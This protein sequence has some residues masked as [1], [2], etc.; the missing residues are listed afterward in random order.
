MSKIQIDI[1]L[2][3]KIVKKEKWY[4]SSCPVLDIYS[5]GNT[6]EEANSNIIEALTI[7]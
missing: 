6:E 7:F 1:K 3:V 5:Q 4:V 2:P